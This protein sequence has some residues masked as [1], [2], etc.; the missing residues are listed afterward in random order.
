[1]RDQALR[2]WRRLRTAVSRGNFDRELA[3]ELEFHL[4]PAGA[5]RRSP[6][7]FYSS[8]SGLAPRPDAS[9]PL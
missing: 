3:Q 6:C 8:F 2:L 7:R 9:A 5:G 1:M 4:G